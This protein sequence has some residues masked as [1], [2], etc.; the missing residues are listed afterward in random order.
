MKNHLI[1]LAMGLLSRKRCKSKIFTYRTSQLIKII[2]LYIFL[3]DGS[4][5]NAFE[6][7]YQQGQK[8]PLDTQKRMIERR[9]T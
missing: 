3:Y 8:R 7:Y 1:I 2:F 9:E 4:I 6:I 5:R